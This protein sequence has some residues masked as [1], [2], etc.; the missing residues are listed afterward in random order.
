MLTLLLSVSLQVQVAAPVPADAYADSATRALVIAARA[1]RERNERLVTSYTVTARQRLGVGISA[2]SRDRMLFRQELAV[3]IDWR[4]DSTS[5][6]TVVGAREAA[7]IATRG[8]QLP[9]SL[10]SDVRDL[11]IDPG[12]DYLRVTGL[13]GG[14]GGGTEDGFLYPLRDGAERDYRFAIGG[15]T[16]IGLPSGRQ[17]RLVALDVTPRRA[18]WQLMSGTLWFDEDTYGLVRLAFRPARPFELQR[19]LDDDDEVPGWVNAKAEVRF[20]TL[21]Y[22]LHDSRWWMPRHVAID[23][24][25]SMGSWLNVPIRIE[26]T[27]EDYTV[28]GGTPPDPERPFTPAG[29]RSYERRDLDSATV[30]SLQAV[31]RECVREA[32]ASRDPDAPDG[33]AERRRIRDE[34]ADCRAAEEGNLTVIV[35]DDTLALLS[36]PELG[37]PILAM[38]DVLT[39]REL[40]SMRDAIENLPDRPWDRRLELP[41]GV[42]SLLRHARY[43]RVEALS[44]GAAGRLELGKLHVA[45]MARIGLADGEPNGELAVVRDPI[46]RRIAVTAYRRLAAANPEVRPHGVVNSMMALLAG[47]DDGEYFRTRGVE[48]SLD[49][50][51]TGSWSARFYHE[52]QTG[53]AVETNA[54][55]PRLFD[56]ERTFRPNILAQPASQTGAVLALRAGRPLSR[57]VTLGVEAVVEAATGDFD[58]GRGAVTLRSSVTPGGPLAGALTLAIGTSTSEVPV[59]SGYFLGGAATLRGYPGGVATGNAFWRVRAEVGNSLPAVRLIGFGDLGW[60][61]DRSDFGNGRTLIGAGIGASFLDGLIRVDLARALREPTGTRL[62]IYLDGAL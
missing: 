36:A 27:Y 12:S 15:R 33:D 42:S 49:N 52:R 39:E 8:D 7:P 14:G 2:L 21:E 61:G 25:G 6:V 24:L 46:G 60:A 10:R 3:R 44:I 45:G 38:G 19:D 5:E 30:D 50:T 17:V 57:S 31:L 29:R 20:I 18:D 62:E 54:S 43:N 23:A 51:A 58:F 48:L 32:R 47:R 16:V 37:P 59:Q 53:A 1:A 56:G 11:V 35:P 4:R 9:V 41:R 26:R 34:I 13:A 22:G 40:L 55:L 28:E